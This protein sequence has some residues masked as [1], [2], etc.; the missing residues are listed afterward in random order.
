MQTYQKD[1]LQTKLILTYSFKIMQIQTAM[2][3]KLGQLLRGR[4]V[5]ED[6]SA[7][8]GWRRGRRGITAL[9]L[10]LSIEFF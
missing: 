10:S 8:T 6:A 1:A 3:G 2:S 5:Q 7:R 9:S 4:G